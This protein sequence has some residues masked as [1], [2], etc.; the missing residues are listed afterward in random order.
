MCLQQLRK[1]IVW[2]IENRPHSEN[3]EKTMN[4][5]K[6]SCFFLIPEAEIMFYKLVWVILGILSV[7]G[8]FVGLAVTPRK[9][10][11]IDIYQ[12]LGSVFLKILKTR[13]VCLFDQFPNTDSFWGLAATWWKASTQEMRVWAFCY[14]TTLE[15]MIQAQAQNL[16]SL[17]NPLWL[18]MGISCKHLASFWYQ[19]LK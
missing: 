12:A 3:L 8:N 5:S 17:T 16:T 4:D 15:L 6:E 10:Y 7:V 14:Y 13:R 11:L 2:I 9:W 18:F 1:M 19:K